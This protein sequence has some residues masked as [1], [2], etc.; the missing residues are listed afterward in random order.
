[1][2]LRKKV[3]FILGLILAGYTIV[4]MV[5]QLT[6]VYPK[7]EHMEQEQ[8]RKHLER[9]IEG[10]NGE[11]GYVDSFARDWAFW[12]DTYQFVESLDEPYR[13]A[14]LTFKTFG[15]LGL[16]LLFIIDNEGHVVWGKTYN[17]ETGEALNFKELPS[18]SWPLDH[19]L[20]THGNTA[21]YRLGFYNLEPVPV[22]V[23]S[24]PILTSQNEGPSRGTLIFGK[25]ADRSFMRNL[26]EKTRLNLIIDPLEDEPPSYIET[27][28]RLLSGKPYFIKN[29]D[30][31]V[32]EGGVLYSDLNGEP[33]ISIHFTQDRVITANGRESLFIA[34]LSTLAVGLTA[35]IF[36]YFAL[37]RIILD[38]LIKLTSHVKQ[39]IQTEDLS[40]RIELRR[41]D[42]LGTLAREFDAL[43]QKLHHTR[44]ALLEQTKEER[45][46]GMTDAL[47]GLRNRRYMAQ[48]M[49]IRAVGLV[50][51]YK[52]LKAERPDTPHHHASMLFFMIDVDFFKA[53]NDNY[54]HAAG[55]R[56]LIQFKAVLEEV[57]RDTDTLIRWGGE[58][59]MVICEAL[60]FRLG[61]QV[62]ERIREAV[63]NYPFTLDDGTIIHK[64]CSIGFAPFPFHP[65][66][67][68]ALNWEDVVSVADRA[69]YV[70]KKNA[71]N[72]WVGIRCTQ[73]VDPEALKGNL[74][75]DIDKLLESQRLQVESSIK[76]IFRWN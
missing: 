11:L 70:A 9:I 52:K 33:S 65:E 59:F 58:E 2:S 23:A 55:D 39:I 30:S 34:L 54:G 3:S 32:L 13:K 61:A 56:V 74:A 49:G 66:E 25:F 47:T 69:L 64:T 73:E 71:R 21:D 20:L 41:G 46:A 4:F 57:C 7:F 16:N 17:L 48:N 37:Q 50:R 75:W 26:Q 22:L 42:E 76:R 62:A 35:L 27:G 63:E 72:A 24:R 28:K 8:A 15:D 53:V 19:P 44:E 5:T 43:V 6:F 60:E 18:D 38:P 67:P 10:V 51:H 29:V 36:L 12:D 14:N 45:E 31:K 1:M 40:R 68:E